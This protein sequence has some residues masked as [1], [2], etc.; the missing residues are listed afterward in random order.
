MAWKAP[1]TPLT[2]RERE[3]ECVREREGGREEGM[4]GGR[5][6][7]TATH[8]AL[9]DE[10]VHRH[11]GGALPFTLYLHY[12]MHYTSYDLLYCIVHC[13]GKHLALL[14]ERVHCRRRGALPLAPARAAAAAGGGGGGGGAVGAAEPDVLG[15][16]GV[17]EHRLL[18]HQRQLERAHRM[19]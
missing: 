17:E 13:D 12:I 5:D 14:D 1:G 19:L 2:E 16:G 7:D 6:G 4:E 18:A 15:D 3:R 11:R 8:L 9:L 10:R